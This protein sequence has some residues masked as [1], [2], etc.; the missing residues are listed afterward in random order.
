MNFDF[1]GSILTPAVVASL[2]TLIFNAR[3]EKRKQIREN[4]KESFSEARKL[5]EAAVVASSS[6]FSVDAENRLPSL[7]AKIW[8]CERELRF[9]LT[10]L[11]EKSDDKLKYDLE[12]ARNEF[13]DFIAELTGGSFQVSTA[14]SDLKH[15]RKIAGIGA[16]LRFK[17]SAL[18]FA[19]L[20]EVLQRDPL[21]K[22]L[23]FANKE[24]GISR[25]DP[26][27]R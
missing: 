13:D 8:L 22:L 27:L 17:L 7:E 23:T 20:R 4:L 16:T 5:V 3:N 12:A 25:N 24:Q 6:Y 19:E 1:V 26:D 18:Y 2:F 11:L 21:H 15:V 14:T 10:D 9:T